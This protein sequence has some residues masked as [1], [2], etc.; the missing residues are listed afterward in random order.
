MEQRVVRIYVRIAG[1]IASLVIGW[2]VLTPSLYN[3]GTD[4][5]VWAAVTV[6]ISAPIVAWRLGYRAYREIRK[7]NEDE[8]D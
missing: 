5:A 7:E 4:A 1:A 3:R 8:E 2:G 6:T